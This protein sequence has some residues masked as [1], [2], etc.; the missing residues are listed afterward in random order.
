MK[1]GTTSLQLAARARREVLLANGVRYPGTEVN[2]RR[3]LGALIGWSVNTWARAK[4]LEPDRLDIDAKGVPPRGD[5]DRVKAE[6]E[7]DPDRRIF[8]THEFVSQVD[9]STA[10]KVVE[11]VG[12]PIHVCITL[13]S[14][15]EIV[16]SLWAQSVRDDA[17]TEPFVDWLARFFGKDPVHPISARFQRAYDQGQ[18]VNRWARLV[19]PDN[20][21]VIVVDKSD[22][23]LLTGTFEA[24]LGL[25]DGV[26]EWRPSNA[27]LAAI[28]AELFRHVNA[29]LRDRGAGWS[30][31]HSLVRYG[32]IK[33]GPE[34]RQLS[35]GEP[36][37]VLPSWAG[38]IARRDGTQFADAIRHSG[39]RIVGDVDTIGAD[40]RT[41]DWPTM[42][43]VPIDVAAEAV[44]GGILA[45]QKARTDLSKEVADR[46][47]EINRLR[48]DLDRVTAERDRVT[49]DLAA[50]RSSS[51]R[52]RAREL[53]Q[54]LRRTVL[55]RLRKR[56]RASLHR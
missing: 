23:R 13:R 49:A 20:V 6:I 44:A 38:E 3:Q 42:S 19:G 26:L 46:A 4:P 53:A 41:A 9:D 35:P 33:L 12:E 36:R 47:A 51:T 15:G 18:L 29:I 30:T 2:Q 34:R 55:R 39:V 56:Q 40:F 14:P 10:R 50:L 21:T 52:E 28:D 11:A 43:A 54:E 5:W 8:L 17:Q 31:F 24:M 27:S 45:G 1:T 7:A 48:A 16:P 22:P 37:V 32:A 25:P